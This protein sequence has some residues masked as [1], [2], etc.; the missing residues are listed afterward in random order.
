MGSEMCIR[1]RLRTTDRFT[2]ND[3]TNVASIESSDCFALRWTESTPGRQ[4]SGETR[5]RI[6]LRHR[7]SLGTRSFN[8]LKSAHSRTGRKGK[9]GN[10]LPTTIFP[11][12]LCTIKAIRASVANRAREPFCWVKTNGPED[13]VALQKQNVVCIVA[14]DY[15]LGRYPITRQ[16]HFRQSR[17]MICRR[18][19]RLRFQ[20]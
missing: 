6:V 13:G 16:I 2:K 18:I 4:P 5:A 17:T 20:R 3:R 7:S 8:S 1:D 10:S 12:I 14:I 9:S 11:T 15:G 19:F